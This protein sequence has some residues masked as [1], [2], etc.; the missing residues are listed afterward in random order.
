LIVCTAC[1]AT[2]VATDALGTPLHMMATGR[3]KRDLPILRLL[4]TVFLT[5]IALF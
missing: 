2:N 4:E 1:P 5:L 3:K